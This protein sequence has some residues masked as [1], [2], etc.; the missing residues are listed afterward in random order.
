VSSRAPEDEYYVLENKE[1]KW[2]DVDNPL[3]LAPSQSTPTRHRHEREPKKKAK[4]REN[5]GRKRRR[6]R[7]TRDMNIRP[8]QQQRKGINPHTRHVLRHQPPIQRTRKRPDDEEKGEG[9][10]VGADGGDDQA[11]RDEEE[12]PG[13]I[14]PPHAPHLNCF[15][16]SPTRRRRKKKE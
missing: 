12:P 3:P 10:H 7:V 11:D 16:P 8:R 1:M 2:Q 5:G 14:F 15:N 6:T 4:R 13:H 9:H